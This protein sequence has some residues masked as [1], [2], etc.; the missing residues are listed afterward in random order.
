LLVWCAVVIRRF[1]R[2]SA[3]AIR[4]RASLDHREV[5]SSRTGWPLPALEL[6][7]VRPR[8]VFASWE[9]SQGVPSEERLVE[10]I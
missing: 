4:L 10:T 5:R 8:L 1:Q 6:G 7:S 2:D 9:E 3:G